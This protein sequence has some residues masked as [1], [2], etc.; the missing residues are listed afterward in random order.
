M[1]GSTLST[2]GIIYR[3]FD[4]G[5]QDKVINL[6][7]EKGE[8]ISMLAKSARKPSSKK[9]SSIEIGNLVRVKY[10]TGYSIPILTDIST[11]NEFSDW[12]KDF[13]KTFYLQMFCEV[14]G[15]FIQEEFEI[16]EVFLVLKTVLI[17]NDK[18][19]LYFVAALFILKILLYSGNLPKLNES[20]EDGTMLSSEDAYMTNMS[21]GYVNDKS[22]HKT[23]ANTPNI[24]KT[25]RYAEK[26]SI[27]E[28]LRINLPEKEVKQMLNLH[29][30]W[31]EFVIE[32]ELKSKKVILGL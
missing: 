29:I 6:I 18:D 21:I 30:E 14:V 28:T 11:V 4:S 32:R 19:D 26:H 25:Q 16:P 2:T 15:G 27:E 9:S 3:I 5:I 20:I 22:Q 1:T 12:K 7:S 10:L 13:K 23:Y 31:L 24:Y 17:E 8:K